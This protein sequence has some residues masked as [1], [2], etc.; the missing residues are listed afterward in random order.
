M[1]VTADIV[2]VLFSLPALIVGLAVGI[3]VALVTFVLN[4]IGARYDATALDRKQQPTRRNL[5]A[6]RKYLSKLATRP[7]TINGPARWSLT[8]NSSLGAYEV[9]QHGPDIVHD[10]RIDFFDTRTKRQ[11]ELSPTVRIAQFPPGLPLTMSLGAPTRVQ[12]Y[13][14]AIRWDDHFGADQFEKLRVRDAILD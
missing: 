4:R 2:S 1:T 8:F 6:G 14:L 12:H 10:L 5:R 3:T 11:S 7:R 9:E 13:G